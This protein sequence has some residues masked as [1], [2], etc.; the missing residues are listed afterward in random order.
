MDVEAIRAQIP[1]TRECLYF[2]TAG[3]SPSLD[4]VTDCLVEEFRS[5][6]RSGPPLI[7]D[8]ASNAGRLQEAR[9]GLAAFCGVD[10]EDLCLTHGVADGVTTVFNGLDW[11]SGDELILTDEEHPAVTIPAERLPETHGVV[12]KYLPIAGGEREILPRLAELIT[13]RTRILTLSHVTTD[14]GTKLPAKE[15]VDLAHQHDV[16]VLYDGAQSLGQFPVD[17]VEIGA[18]FY[19]ILV[20]KWM[21]GPYSA[22]ALYI[23]KAWQERL[24]VVPSSANYFGNEGA[25]RFEFAAVPPSYYYASASAAAYLTAVGIANIETYVTGLATRLRTELA[26]IPGLSIENPED[27]G[28]CTG[29]VTFRVD[30]VDGPHIST[31]LRNRKIIT[32]PTGLKFSGVRASVSFFTT[33]AEIDTFAAAVAEIVETH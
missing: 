15:I 33:A 14:T 32:R 2:N 27:P 9:V 7:M 13:K 25:R 16:P 10:A 29:I 17:V 1:V 26:E 6:A 8:Y 24:S 21:Y 3:I 19:S 28:M 22:G 30:G 12:L 4:V 18:D 20:Y 23:D 5:I 11:Q 31:Q